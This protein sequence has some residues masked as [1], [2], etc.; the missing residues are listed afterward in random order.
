MR[1]K[2]KILFFANFPTKDVRS[3]GGAAT[4]SKRIY[5]FIKKD[6][7]LDVEHV[8]IRKFWKSKY[9]IID[10]VIWIFRFPF[11][12][13]GYDI[14]SFHTTRDFHVSVAPFLWI[15]AKLFNK[16]IVYHLFGGGFHVQYQRLPKFYRFILRT[17]ILNSDVFVLETKQ[18]VN[19]FE[20][21]GLK[22]I[23]WL[24]NSRKSI[25]NFSKEKKFK[26]KF[27]FISRIVPDKGI[28]E[29]IEAASQLPDDYQ[30][31]VFGPIDKNYYKTNPFINTRV[32][33]KGILHHDKVIETLDEY[34]ILLMPT[35]IDREGYPG[36]IIEALSIGVPV[37]TTDC[38]VMNEMITHE[39]NGLLIKKRSAKALE[40]GIK[41]FN[42]KNYA[43]YKKNALSSFDNFNSENVFKKLINAYFTV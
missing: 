25:P 37:I 40:D 36:I 30:I 2:V 4:L 13:R 24:P 16:K 17:T 19:Y 32:N 9:Q 7:N 8:Q 6:S 1:G 3:I 12:I 43:V 11:M 20:A 26:K 34:D 15:W 28:P 38:C 35:Y 5:D 22:N 27:V 33:Y 41:F 23:I 39:Y 10:Y 14:I 31:D 29:I 21:I 18:L 42:E